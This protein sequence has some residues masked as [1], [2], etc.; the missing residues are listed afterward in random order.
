MSFDVIA[1]GLSDQ[2]M[3]TVTAATAMKECSFESKLLNLGIKQKYITTCDL[4]A[5]AD[6]LEAVS[7]IMEQP[8]S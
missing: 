1:P 7:I 4:M 3:E 8:M 2:G 5:S 6:G